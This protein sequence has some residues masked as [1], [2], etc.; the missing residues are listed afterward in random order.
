MS[1]MSQSISLY[2][3]LAKHKLFNKTINFDLKR[4]KLALAKLDHPEEKLSN[5]IQIIGSDGKYSVLRALRFFIE[6]NN[7]TVSTHVSPSLKDIRE[8]FWMGKN[9][10]AHGEIRKT[11]KIIEKLKIP[12][13]IYE[14]LTLIFIINASQRKNDYCIQEAGALW[15]LDSN[16][17]INFPLK[18][19]VVNINKQ[20]LNFLKK[21]TLDEVIYQ[22]VGFLNQFTDIY[23]G[24]QK[25]YVLKKIKKLLKKNYSQIKYSSSWKLIKTK[26]NYYYQDK[27]MRIKLNTKYIHSKGLLENICLAIKISLD[28]KIDKKIII[29]TIPKIKLQARIQYITK[30]KLKKKIFKNEKILIDGCHSEVSAKNLFDYLKTLNIPIYGIWAMT[31]NKNA[32]KFIKQFKGIFK[33]IITIPIKNE[34][35]SMSN[36]LLYKLAKKNNYDSK[37]AESFEEALR[38]ISSKEEKVICVFG[39]LYLCGNI[40]NKN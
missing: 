19:I 26:K 21:K 33:K 14:V 18:Q 22:K 34:P 30:G 36:T 39:S 24:K 28:L 25:P 1:L 15:R 8:R 31:K 23:I 3:Q 2:N 13:T 37:K 5:V 4:I 9:Y 20:H 35:A 7:Q 6:E 38:Y 29:K 40:L 11:I 16:N 10:L 17:V 12:L 27:K 32:D